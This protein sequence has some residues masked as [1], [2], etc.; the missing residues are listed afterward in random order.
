MHPGT[1][2]HM[3]VLVA[4]DNAIS[5]ALIEN[6]LKKWGYRGGPCG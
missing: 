2:T 4:E 5:R 1:P 3:K 6:M